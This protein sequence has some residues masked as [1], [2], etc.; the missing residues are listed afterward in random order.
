[1]VS[2]PGTKCEGGLLA[3]SQQWIIQARQQAQ[4]KNYLPV[5]LNIEKINQA[6]PA[7]EIRILPNSWDPGIQAQE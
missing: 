1:M 3:C 6:A 7:R 2:Q 5:T 4:R